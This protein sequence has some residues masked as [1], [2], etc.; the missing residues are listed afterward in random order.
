LKAGLQEVQIKYG[1]GDFFTHV[2]VIA[3]PM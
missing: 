2:I 1:P 3:R